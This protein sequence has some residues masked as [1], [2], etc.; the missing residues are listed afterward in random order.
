MF[1]GR[2]HA[3]DESCDARMGRTGAEGRLNSCLLRQEVERNTK[4]SVFPALIGFFEMSM[5][6][7]CKKLAPHT[8]KESDVPRNMKRYRNVTE[9]LRFCRVS[10]CRYVA[11]RDLFSKS[12]FETRGWL[13]VFL[14]RLARTLL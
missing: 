11:F 1:H 8:I 3:F 2:Y 14:L 6:Q 7:R 10:A 9:T 5:H 4:G 13:I 12:I